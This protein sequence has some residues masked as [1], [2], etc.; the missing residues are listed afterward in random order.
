MK[1]Y[2]EGEGLE[3]ECAHNGE[4]ALNFYK[5]SYDAES[6]Y[7]FFIIFMDIN[8]PIM[9]GIEGTKKIREF[10]KKVSAKVPI[11]GVT[12]NFEASI[13]K[14]CKKSGMTSVQMKPFSYADFKDII[15]IYRSIKGN[16]N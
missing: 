9:D 7:R 4:E 13:K 5:Q 16:N 2:A 12:A 8:M 15:S 1:Q 3:Y 10:E 6:L 14:E 11:V